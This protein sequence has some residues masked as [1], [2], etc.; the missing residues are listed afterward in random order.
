MLFTAFDQYLIRKNH[1]VLVCITDNFGRNFVVI[2]MNSKK[3]LKIIA[4]FLISG[5]VVQAPNTS[6]NSKNQTPSQLENLIG[7]V[8]LI[9]PS[10]ESTQQ[11][12]VIA[13]N[14]TAI[15]RFDVLESDFRYLSMKIKHCNADWSQSALQDLEYL[16]V[17]NEFPIRNYQFSQTNYSDY[18]SYQIEIPRLK[19]SGNYLLQIYDE[20]TNETLF[21][22]KLSIYDNQ[23]PIQTTIT[24]S[25]NP[26]WRNSHHKIDY[27][28]D[29]SSLNIINPDL[30]LKIY[31]V[32]NNNWSNAIAP[33]PPTSI[34]LG[35]G[36]ISYS[37]FDNQNSIPAGNEFRFFDTRRIGNK[38]LRVAD[39]YLIEN[40]PNVFLEKDVSRSGKAYA[41]PFQ[42]D[43]NGFF[44]IGNQDI[45][46][47]QL[48]TEYVQINFTLDATPI[49]GAVFVTGRFN[50]W[51]KNARNQMKYDSAAQAY[52]LKMPLKQ[53]YYNYR[54]EV[55]SQTIR[56]N[57][58]EGSHFQTQNTYEIYAYYREPG[59]VFDQL[60]GYIVF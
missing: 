1:S 19:K 17:Y 47:T 39:Q 5:C 12:P 13:L 41:E 53:G 31:C 23:I 24:R 14:R 60:A 9:N 22:R 16:D 43:L 58:F 46:E 7:L 37:S 38:G 30:D 57:Q 34:D 3:H 4:L 29:I 21:A 10:S 35:R 33:I 59:T 45:L 52:K 11:L 25:E 27:A 40:E 42:I 56:E 50:N 32:Q 36:L 49:N 51:E 8:E 20:D 54:Y 2:E 26:A 15:L 6:E 18:T 28:I 48:N 44:Q 55:L